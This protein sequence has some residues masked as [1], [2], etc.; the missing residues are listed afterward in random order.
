[1]TPRFETWLR[2]LYAP[3]MLVGF[4]GLAIWLITAGAGSEKAGPCA[5]GLV[6]GRARDP[7]SGAVERA[8][9]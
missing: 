5:K 7:V 4:N 3:L 8:A 9:G 6:C 1:M 2:W